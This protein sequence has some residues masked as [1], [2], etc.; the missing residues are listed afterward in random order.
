MESLFLPRAGLDAAACEAM[1]ALLAARHGGGRLALSL[2]DLQQNED[3][4]QQGLSALVA[5]A[6]AL[7][8][9]VL[10][11]AVGKQ[12]RVAAEADGESLLDAEEGVAR[13]FA[14]GAGRGGGANSPLDW[15][16]LLI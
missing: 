14:P 5:H 6:A 13:A 1:S 7:G 10:G 11:G 8:V 9:R 4:S 16:L 15:G 2:L 3:F 12:Q